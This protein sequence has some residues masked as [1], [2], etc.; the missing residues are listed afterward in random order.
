MPLSRR[1]FLLDS[2]GSTLLAPLFR[3]P[4]SRRG[5]PFRHGVASG[6]ALTDRVILWTRISS[7]HDA[8]S[9]GFR[10]VV[11][12]DQDLKKYQFHRTLHQNKTSGFRYY[13]EA[14]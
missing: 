9:V 4:S 1:E 11:A 2:A 12:L 13:K 5:F 8:A 14:V 6:D 10:Y 3:L 7:D